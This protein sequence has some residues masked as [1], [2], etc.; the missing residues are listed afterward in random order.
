V[1]WSRWAVGAAAAAI[2]IA[3]PYLIW[4]QVHGWPQ[5]TVAHNIA[6]SAEGG[7]IGFIPF[8]LVMVSP[9]LVPVWIAGLIA[10]FRAGGPRALRFVTVTY[11]AVGLAYLIGDGKAYYL[12]SLYPVLLGIGAVRVAAWGWA[13]TWVLAVAIGLSAVVS[14]FIALPLLPERSLQGSLPMAINPDLGE[15]VG[16]P[17]FI[18]TVTGAWRSIP[19]A[20][21][22]HTAI[23]T[24]NYGE[25]GAVDILGGSLPRA[26]S[27]HNGFSE[28]GM[29]PP[30][31]T[32][33]LLLGYEG[34]GDTLPAFTSCHRLARIDDGVGLNNDEQ[35]GPVLFC[36]TTAPWPALWPGL[37]HFN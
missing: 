10:P 37:R 27:G 13:R 5:L 16:W 21:R 32:H 12:A 30:A 25:A 3:L 28:W 14:A 9:I 24:S 29:P 6:G 34:N 22:A 15:Q 17:R 1:L 35:D 4:Q 20:E 19:A 26:Y 8:Q 36:R 7:R 31:D 33:V 23:F 11:A 18:D 2:A